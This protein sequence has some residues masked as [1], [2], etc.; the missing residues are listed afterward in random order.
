MEILEN[1]MNIILYGTPD[2]KIKQRLATL[3]ELH[4]LTYTYKSHKVTHVEINGRMMAASEAENYISHW[5]SDIT[6]LR[7]L[8]ANGENVTVTFLKKDGSKR[9]MHCTTNFDYIP[10]D[11]KPKTKTPVKD[12]NN[13]W[14]F[15]VFDIAAGDWRSFQAQTILEIR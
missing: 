7:S 3:F 4:N 1:T 11:K 5:L 8:L 13:P 15:K 6:K 12:E 9:I 10:A 14:L 2:C